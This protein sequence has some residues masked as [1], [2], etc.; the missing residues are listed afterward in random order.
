MRG[1]VDACDGFFIK[2]EDKFFHDESKLGELCA[3]LE[4]LLEEIGE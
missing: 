1:E 2:F 3:K 4:G